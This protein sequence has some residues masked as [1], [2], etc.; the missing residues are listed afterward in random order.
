MN[1]IKGSSVT[2]REK[3]QPQVF[4]CEALFVHKGV[5]WG[6]PKGSS[7]L[8]SGP[9]GAGKSFLALALARGML[10]DP[11]LAPLE[12]GKTQP[13][14]LRKNHVIY[15]ISAELDRRRF[16]RNFASTGWLD[17]D[18]PAFAGWESNRTAI[19]LGRKSGV[20]SLIAAGVNLSRPVPTSE[21]MINA[22][23][24]ELRLRHASQPPGTTAFV[25]VDSLTALLRDC[26]TKGEE[27]RQT[28]EFIRRLET[29][30]GDGQLALTLFIWEA[31][32]NEYAEPDIEDYV[33]DFVFRLGV[34][35]TG[36]GRRLRT[37]EVIKSHG[38]H[39]RL[40]EHTWA[41]ITNESASALLT[42]P[43]LQ[44]VIAKMATGR[45][46]LEEIHDS[47][48]EQYVHAPPGDRRWAT[49]AIFASRALSPIGKF[50]RPSR[51]QTDPEELLTGVPGLDQMLRFQDKDVDGLSYWTRREL[52]LTTRENEPAKGGLKP[53]ST[54]LIVGQ[55]G[56]GKTNISIQFL[57]AD[58]L[59]RGKV[60]DSLF[61]NF[62]LPLS[63]LER[64]FPAGKDKKE[65]LNGL[66]SLYRRRGNL[67]VNCLLAEIRFVVLRHRIRRIAIDGLSS[68]LSTTGEEEYAQLI[69]R[70][71]ST[72][73]GLWEEVPQESEARMRR[74]VRRGSLKI[75]QF[76][77]T[78]RNA[79]V[80][81]AWGKVCR[82]VRRCSKAQIALEEA[83]SET[84]GLE[85]MRA[86]V[87][88]AEQAL[89]AAQDELSGVRTL[90]WE[91]A[92]DAVKMLEDSM[93]EANPGKVRSAQEKCQSANVELKMVR[94]VSELA[95]VGP[96]SI[97][98]FITYE[99][100]RMVT[101]IH[102]EVP[103][104]S[105]LADNLL[106]I[107]PVA[108]NDEIRHAVYLAKARGSSHDK[109]VREIRV[110]PLS[111]EPVRIEPG[112]ESYTGLLSDQPQ[113]VTL[114]LQL[115]HENY[116]QELYHRDLQRRLRKVFNYK[117][118]VF[119]FSRNAISRTLRELTA[120][121]TRF[122]STHVRVI[123]LDEWVINDL[124][125]RSYIEYSKQQEKKRVL[126]PLLPL[127]PFL[128]PHRE[129]AD[130]PPRLLHTRHSDFWT[131]DLDKAKMEEQPC[132]TTSRKLV[133]LPLYV[134]YGIFCVN[135]EIARKIPGFPAN[136]SEGGIPTRE[137]W[138]KILKKLPRNW[139]ERKGEWFAAPQ[140]KELTKSLVNWMAAAIEASGELDCWG[141][142][143][144]LATPE[145]ASVMF[146]E[147]CWAFGAKEDIFRFDNDGNIENADAV[148]W[149]MRFLMFL[150]AEK[151]MP[152][153]VSGDQSKGALFSRHWYSTFS[154]TQQSRPARPASLSQGDSTEEVAPPVSL[155]IV[156]FFPTGVAGS[157]AE[158]L[159]SDIEARTAFATDDLKLGFGRVRPFM[160]FP[161]AP[162]SDG[163]VDWN[164]GV[165]VSPDDPEPEAGD[166]DYRDAVEFLRRHDLRVA[167][168]S[169]KDLVGAI[170]GWC[171][172]SLNPKK[173]RPPLGKDLS[174]ADTGRGRK[175][176]NPEKAVP[177]GTGY[178]CTG[179]WMVAVHG[180][181]HS[182]GL[183]CKLIDE[184]TSLE[185]AVKRARAG[186][187]LPSRKD[188]YEYYG[189]ET[190]T[191]APYLTW[192]ELI[193]F[194]GARARRRQ[195]AAKDVPVGV[196]NAII[197]RNVRA[198][199][200]AAAL[201]GKL[202]EKL[203][204][205]ADGFAQR[206]IF[207]MRK[208]GESLRKAAKE[209]EKAE[210]LVTRTP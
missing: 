140:P 153:E 135:T 132:T 48:V 161:A 105:A 90:V 59:R 41:I 125:H 203:R 83:G 18:D 109:T 87:T 45:L 170:T 50:D 197:H 97:T 3:Y 21:E 69:E 116:A 120:T 171:N 2:A 183:S 39:L 7:I 188:F 141:F 22:I 204:K 47:T 106:V 96:H 91:E 42:Q 160:T 92:A 88:R 113:P 175:N 70:L 51:W 201:S 24:V 110:L 61:V 209:I 190:V 186:A 82:A 67:D 166:R 10:F 167:L 1:L 14:R 130:D 206:T 28:H 142:I 86:S 137:D 187:G 38:A 52:G 127:S 150:V 200:E 189:D 147:L 66:K 121:E 77:F 94:D 25:I 81:T 159:T 99:P 126:L 75:R 182:A 198:A 98:I 195:V 131:W 118:T 156:P 196:M 114:A 157:L 199:L 93:R 194:C 101:G 208:S 154:D 165:D 71:F 103:R 163:Y 129:D 123:M 149:A 65:R 172:K 144:D 139:V 185:N 19:G 23:L 148:R 128:D 193:G 56:A 85:N 168:A 178:C 108:I 57:L 136:G 115:F 117:V 8:I 179:V 164:F 176:R 62:E 162:A 80:R 53:G 68:L 151:L 95:G 158:S 32:S 30:L 72:I 5:D 177:V 192:R 74:D 138:K 6:F 124:E 58:Y 73:D 181:T 205:I 173:K 107:R 146:L 134:D 152:A 35:D 143:F 16:E 40:G 79:A 29:A 191:F 207:E 55:A 169:G 133:A 26:R 119:G 17:G 104:L 174:S 112:L 76:I 64:R 180:H 34:K 44:E 60:D 100:N 4:D 46:R 11:P 111:D 63:E 122:P 15:F 54:T 20:F 13:T 202:S 43:E 155:V 102:T 89:R 36:G 49:A 33:V 145:T 84:K 78:G 31:P 37:F 184:M 27:R 12:K 210:T 9:P